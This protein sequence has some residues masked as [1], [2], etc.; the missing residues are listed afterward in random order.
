VLPTTTGKLTWTFRR[1]DRGRTIR[2]EQIG[3]VQLQFVEISAERR[4]VV[5]AIKQ[6]ELDAYEQ[7]ISSWEREHLLLKL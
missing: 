3:K 7:V 2:A 6:A 4:H 5:G 1:L